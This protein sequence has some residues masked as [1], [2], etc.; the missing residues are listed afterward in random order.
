MACTQHGD[1]QILI[2]A[3]P[4]GRHIKNLELGH[5]TIE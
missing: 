2:H 3:I 1:S 5:Y 4:K